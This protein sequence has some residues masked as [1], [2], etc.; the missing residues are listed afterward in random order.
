MRDF[1]GRYRL[2]SCRLENARTGT[3]RRRFWRPTPAPMYGDPLRL[4]AC[5]AVVGVHVTMNYSEATYRVG[6][7]QWWYCAMWDGASGGRCRHL[8]CSAGPC[9]WNQVPARR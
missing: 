2:Q 1:H 9:Y 5:I 4:L 6:T 3:E 7:P 8:S